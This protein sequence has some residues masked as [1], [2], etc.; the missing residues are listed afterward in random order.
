[1]TDHGV[2]VEHGDVQLLPDAAGEGGQVGTLQYDG[3]DLRVILDA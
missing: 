3:T 1:M 2:E